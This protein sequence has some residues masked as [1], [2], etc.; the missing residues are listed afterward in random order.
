MWANP[1]T[2]K[3]GAVFP[4]FA[5]PWPAGAFSIRMPA[6][7]MCCPGQGV[8]V[9]KVAISAEDVV[10]GLALYFRTHSTDALVMASH[11]RAGLSALH[12]ASVAAE[13]AQITMLTTLILGPAAKP[14]VDTATGSHAA[15]KTVL[16]PV[17]H[18]PAPRGA[19]RRLDALAQGLDVQFDY[20]HVGSRAPL[21]F[22][23]RGQLRRVRTL[24]GPVVETL[25][26]EAEHADMIAMPMVGR[27]GLLD[28]LR[29]STTERIVRD[30]T[31]PV[32]ALPA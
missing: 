22:D 28:A 2:M 5:K 15:I 21:L 3:I 11:G 13:L 29:G 31:R 9:K 23:G 12:D 6:E 4:T 17:D 19:I 32:L 10:G 24:Q 14:F 30:A 18:E 16:V 1:E 20:V 27:D 26:T 25:L 8:S 7:R